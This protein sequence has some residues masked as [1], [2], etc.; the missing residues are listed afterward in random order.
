MKTATID[1]ITHI[2]SDTLLIDLH[3]FVSPYS[4]LE[5]FDK[6]LRNSL[7][8]SDKLN[9]ILSFIDTM[10]KETIYFLTDNYFINYVFLFPFPDKD[11]LITLGPYFNNTIDEEYWNKIIS[12]NHLSVND[13]KKIK[14]YLY[15]IPQIENNL[16]LNSVLSTIISYVNN[17]ENSPF[18][19]KYL[20]TYTDT[21][22]PDFTP[23][24]DFK[25][26]NKT[27]FDRYKLERYLLECIRKGDSKEALLAAKKFISSPSE[28]RLKNMLR[29]QKLL[30]T[31]ANT[32]FR[33][34]VEENEIH[35]IYLHEISS[36]YVS[37]I[38][39]T[40]SRSALDMV[41]E[42]MI[43][44]YCSLVNNKSRNKYSLPVKNI[45]DYIEFNFSSTITLKDLSDRFSLSIPYISSQ[46]KKEVGITIIHFINQ[47]RIN[48]AIELLN[49]GSMSIQDIAATVGI[50]DYNYFT[51]IFK[52]EIGMTPTEFRKKRRYENH[53]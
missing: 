10:E 42:N 41:Y 14:S 22:S 24:E 1:F 27:I 44:E 47:L 50:L 6:N 4:D 46:F 39:L 40:N 2:L 37:K 26:Y 29:D 16:H 9:T 28:P 51:K 35:P 3:Y 38:E 25:A 48:T 32:L 20:N 33:K 19:I 7:V 30:L 36:K 34:A 31:S 12:E 15:N 43:I 49:G 11:D 23:K 13:L 21:D 18:K 45:L 17:G 8:D 52:K 5:V 53:A